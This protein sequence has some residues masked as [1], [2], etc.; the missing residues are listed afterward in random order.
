[1]YVSLPQFLCIYLFF[2]FTII[3]AD[4]HLPFF[5]LLFIFLIFVSMPLVLTKTNAYHGIPFSS[6]GGILD[7]IKCLDFVLW[8]GCKQPSQIWM[9]W[10]MGLALLFHLR[11]ASWVRTWLIKN[12]FFG[13][14]FLD[15]NLS[16]MAKVKLMGGPG[17]HEGCTMEG[18]ER[19][20][21]QPAM[22]GLRWRQGARR[23]WRSDG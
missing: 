8:G 9:V 23:G 2:F 4:T 21:N 17:T 22:R 13:L 18:E 5:S 14:R 6:S 7:A 10:S 15:L 3:V 1:M 12:C 16:S 11:W 20:S 19:K